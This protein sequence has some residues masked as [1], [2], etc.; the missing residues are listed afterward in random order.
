MAFNDI[1]PVRKMMVVGCDYIPCDEHDATHWL[2]EI[3]FDGNDG[4]LI[5]PS[6]EAAEACFKAFVSPYERGTI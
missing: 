5:L 4:F 2:I 3:G 6:R 1:R